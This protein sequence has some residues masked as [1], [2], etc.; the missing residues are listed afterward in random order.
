MI[1]SCRMA[2]VL[3]LIPCISC[4]GS[5]ISPR[6]AK[7]YE[8]VGSVGVHPTNGRTARHWY[9]VSESRT[10]EE[11]AQTLV[12]AATGLYRE[13]GRDVTYV[14]LYPSRTLVGSGLRYATGFYAADG[15]AGEGL[16][17]ADPDYRET[18]SVLATRGVLSPTQL[19][20]AEL[21]MRLAPEFPSR[22]MA[23]SSGVDE[24][25][26][27]SRIAQELHLDVSAVQPP[28]LELERW[29]IEP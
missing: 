14:T 17:G 24:K 3:M 29:Q 16:P 27:R 9:I 7:P 12:R 20:V 10:F 25:A 22:D 15:R 4:A 5:D 23:S 18:W 1:I 28:H 8:I 19:K 11:H 2:G 13:H 21:W 6:D 26:L